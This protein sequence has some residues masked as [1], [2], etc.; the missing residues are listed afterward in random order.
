MSD[1][2]FPVYIKPLFLDL[3]NKSIHEHIH[4]NLLFGVQP[5]CPE[6]LSHEQHVV[7]IP[8][9]T[10][11][12][13]KIINNFK[14]SQIRRG[15][16]YIIVAILKSKEPALEILRYFKLIHPLFQILKTLKRPFRQ[17]TY[18]I[19]RLFFFDRKGDQ[20]VFQSKK[21]MSGHHLLFLQHIDITE[22]CLLHLNQVS[23]IGSL[24]C[25]GLPGKLIPASLEESLI[26]DLTKPI[27]STRQQAGAIKGKLFRFRTLASSP[28]HF[29]FKHPVYGLDFFLG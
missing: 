12:S 15:V 22:R 6:S 23:G 8:P 18:K 21:R 26:S 14:Q 19:S 27:F 2:E 16:I 4:G 29:T 5:N 3:F 7:I 1:E 10:L 11:V 13:V 20:I 25:S 28:R 9:V 24:H 17:K